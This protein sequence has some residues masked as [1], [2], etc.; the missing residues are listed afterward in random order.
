M[1]S[2]HYLLDPPPRVAFEWVKGYEREL[3]GNSGNGL[4][5][6]YD[7]ET[8]NKGEDESDPAD[9]PTYQIHRIGF[10]YRAG[11]ALSVSFTPEYYATIRLLLL[12][13]G[14]KVV[15]NAGFDN[16]RL[17][18]NGFTING[19]IH[20]GMVAWHILHSD[21]PKGLGFV[22][23]F[24]CPWQPAWKHLGS[25]MPAFY[26]ATDADVELQSMMVIREELK[27]AGLWDVYQKDVL[28]LDPILVHMHKVG[29]PIDE[30]V[31][32]RHAVSLADKLALTMGDMEA[33]IPLAARK[34][35]HVYKKT[36]LTTD[37]LRSR[38]GHREVFVCDR[39]G[40]ET[41]T[42]PHFRNL[43]KRVNPC[44]GGGRVKRIIE[45]SEYYRL[46]PFTPSRDQL[47]RYQAVLGRP[48]PMTRDKK[49]KKMK[50]TMDEKAIK[51]LML[52]Y[53]T[54]QL[55][56]LVLAYRELDKLAGTYIGRPICESA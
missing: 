19:T 49:T 45:V 36:P 13:V 38:P 43:K 23:T 24:T 3:A 34:V 32:Y 16:P 26:N 29:M 18:Y 46:S 54:D 51:G 8:P 22:A 42:K 17:E 7:I 4:L 35:E 30:E 6:A 37:G 2:T 40:L 12:S 52:K 20:D 5:L 21:L 53:P 31:R 48:V 33:L 15:W 47:M 1:A 56:P 44:A 55:Y 50:P 9:D 10:S 11:E 41:P 27:K 25:S 28:D 14:E 39:C